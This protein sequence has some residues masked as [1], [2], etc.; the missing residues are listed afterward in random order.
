[1]IDLSGKILLE[2]QANASGI[3]ILDGLK[4]LPSGTYLLQV[5]HE[6]G[7]IEVARVFKI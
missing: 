6:K 4:R 1:L 5:V 7:R 2:K 3:T